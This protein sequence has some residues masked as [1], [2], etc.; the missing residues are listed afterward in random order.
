M[1]QEQTAEPVNKNLL[2]LKE[3]IELLKKRNTSIEN[4]WS[5]KSKDLIVVTLHD[6]TQINVNSET[7]ASL[8]DK[9]NEY[10]WQ[11]KK[12][13]VVPTNNSQA[14]I[15]CRNFMKKRIL[16]GCNSVAV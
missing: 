13:E 14:A 2:T 12:V 7:A 11:A 8:Y 6:G 5:T 1:T 4:L 10:L 16:I 9:Q 3:I 15:I